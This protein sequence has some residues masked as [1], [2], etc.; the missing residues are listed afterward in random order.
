[1]V[2]GEKITAW[3]DDDLI[4]VLATYAC[5]VSSEW[6]AGLLHSSHV[7][8]PRGMPAAQE[9]QFSVYG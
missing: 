6:G 1:M 3:C 9:P 8:A 4:S 5:L 7:S 2:F